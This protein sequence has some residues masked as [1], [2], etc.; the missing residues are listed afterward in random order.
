MRQHNR[1]SR[2]EYW[3]SVAHDGLLKEDK[4]ENDMKEQNHNVNV[5]GVIVKMVNNAHL[6]GESIQRK[7]YKLR[8]GLQRSHPW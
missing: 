1:G 5:G 4:Y 6:D 7:F 2:V 8:L 3:I